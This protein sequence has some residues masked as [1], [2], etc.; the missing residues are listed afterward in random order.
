MFV[1]AN[2]G[3]EPLIIITEETIGHPVVD[4]PDLRA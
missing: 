1:A 3:E 4:T 2:K